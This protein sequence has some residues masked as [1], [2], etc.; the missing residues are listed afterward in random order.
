MN[1]YRWINTLMNVGAGVGT[2]ALV[3]VVVLSVL[4][5]VSRPDTCNTLSYDTGQYSY[6][7]SFWPL[8]L[9]LS[10]I[11]VILYFVKRSFHRPARTD[12]K[13]VPG[14]AIAD[15]VEGSNPSVGRKRAKITSLRSEPR[16]SSKEKQ[17]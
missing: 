17:R 12:E 10:I 4:S 7:H 14:G 3:I 11:I 9:L 16:T 1:K 6:L 8:V 13:Q 5:S 15:D 2:A